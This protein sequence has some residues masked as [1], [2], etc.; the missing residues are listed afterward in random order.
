MEKRFKIILIIA[1]V[2]FLSTYFILFVLKEEELFL[3]VTFF[4]GMGIWLWFFSDYE[5]LRQNNYFL[6]CFGISVLYAIYG[7][8]LY[9]HYRYDDNVLMHFGALHPLILLL[10]Q[11]PLRQVYLMLFNKEPKVDRHGK[12]TDL[13]YTVILFIATIILPMVIMEKFG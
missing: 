6:G 1:I 7:I 8:T 4:L 11:R 12:F 3:K 2:L 5:M 9:D 10:V 13:I